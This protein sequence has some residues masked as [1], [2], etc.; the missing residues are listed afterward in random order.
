MKLTR[1]QFIHV[2]A[3]SALLNGCG[4]RPAKDD[5]RIGLA[6]GSGGARGLAHVA[7]LETLDELGIRPHRIAGTSI[8]AVMGALYAA[9]RSGAELR[10]LIGQLTVEDGDTLADILFEKETFKWLEFFDLELGG[11]GLIDSSGFIHYLGELIGHDRFGLLEIPLAVVAADLWSGAQV[12]FRSG[13][14]LPAIKASIAIP[15]IFEPVEYQGR[16][17]VDGGTVN[18]L[19]FDQLPDCDLTIA[20][21]VTGELS[22][23]DGPPSYTETLFYSIHNMEQRILTQ[24]LKEQRPDIYLRPEIRDVRAL[25][26]YRAEEVYRQSSAVTTELKQQLAALMVL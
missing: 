17:L 7:I 2:A 1:R 8:G 10:H 3:A 4:R 16:H 19:P 20:V 24:K 23:H 26:F 15:G 25:Q 18:P 21:D 11:G 5:V 9:G 14:L 12:V 22:G 13:A 6:L